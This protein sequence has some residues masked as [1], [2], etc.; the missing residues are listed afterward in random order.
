MVVPLRT[1]HARGAPSL[2]SFRIMT[3]QPNRVLEIIWIGWLISW[4]AASFWSNRAQKRAAT[5]ETWSYRAAM[6]AGGVLLVP[7][8][9]PLL[10]EKTIWSV[11][12]PVICALAVLMLAGLA[13]TWW[14]RIY[15]GPLW[16]SV[17][18][19]KE[20]HKI[21]DTGP[22]AFVRHPIYSGLIIALIATAAAEARL[23]GLLG[24]AL[25]ILGV[26]MK[27]R[28]EERFLLTELGA[29]TYGAYCLRVPML[30]PFLPRR[31]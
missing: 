18:T 7:W 19:R 28:T 4:V 9:G 10:G 31:H 13:L 21:I 23:S 27:A 25:V 2:W 16:S 30:I 29:E 11:S 26:W 1:R 17:I 6:I 22:Y 5:L 8:T 20:D 12:Y 24:A 14:A 15:L 3:I